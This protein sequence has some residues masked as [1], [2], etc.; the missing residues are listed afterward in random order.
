MAERTA[1]EWTATVHP[2]GAVTPGSSW[3]PPRAAGPDG[4]IA[5]GACV[6]VNRADAT[7]WT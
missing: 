1:I 7:R 2:D 3:N 6:K 4:A 5:G